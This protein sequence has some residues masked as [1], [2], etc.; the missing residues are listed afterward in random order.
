MTRIEITIHGEPAPQG[1]KTRLRS[2]GMREA[3][4][5]TA[6][7]RSTVTAAANKTMA[8]RP[9]L[10]GPLELRATFA[11][12]RPASHYRSGRHAGELK[13]SAPAYR[14]SRPDLDKLVRAIGDALTGVVYRDDA[15][16]AIVR[17]E[18]HYGTPC[19][20]IVIETI[21]EQA[22]SQA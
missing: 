4:P 22:E 11:F 3:N 9:P 5:N 8:G 10:V 12:V 18:K 19:A 15:Q 14:S 6:P 17:A 21:D 7:W 20:H 16:I 13:P 2:G 1:S